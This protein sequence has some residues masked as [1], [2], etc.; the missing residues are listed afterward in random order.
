MCW[1]LLLCLCM[2]I[3]EHVLI[4]CPKIVTSPQSLCCESVREV[5]ECRHDSSLCFWKLL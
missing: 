4:C 3:V 2:Y 1:Y 5:D